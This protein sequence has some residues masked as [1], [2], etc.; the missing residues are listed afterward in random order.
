MSE[1]IDTGGY[2]N[3]RLLRNGSAARII[4]NR[5]EALNAW[6]PGLGSDLLEAIDLVAKDEAVRAVEIRGAGRAFCSGADLK[7]GFGELTESGSPD[8]ESALHSRYHPVILAVRTMPKPVVAALN[9]ATVG[10]ACGLALACDLVVAAKSAYLLLA[11]ANIGLVP[12]GGSSALIPSR[13]GFSRAME[14]ALLAERIPADQ[15]HE[16][17]MVNRVF[18]DE[19]FDE[20]CDQLILRLS[21]G[22]TRAYAGAKRQLNAWCFEDLEDHLSLEASIQQEQA[23]APDFIEGVSAFL[24]QRDAKFTGA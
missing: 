24:Q 14:M 23:S 19:L 10:V 1:W 18:A 16:W 6:D 9:G 12:D 2:E 4:L 22:P 15:A 21:V 3:L 11:F 7:A 5:P 8:L 17:G 20:E 13:T